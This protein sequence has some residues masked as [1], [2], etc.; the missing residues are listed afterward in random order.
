[1]VVSETRAENNSGG[2]IRSMRDLIE[3][4]DRSGELVRVKRPVHR[5]TELMAVLKRAQTELKKAVLFE[6]VEGT[7]FRYVGNLFGGRD[8]LAKYDVFSLISY[9]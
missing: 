8:K 7:D 5:D 2:P 4:L 6:N 1:M 3:L 9:E